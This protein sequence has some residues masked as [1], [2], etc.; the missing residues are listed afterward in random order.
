M[1]PALPSQGQPLEAKPKERRIRRVVILMAPDGA[2]EVSRKELV[3]RDRADM[4][5]INRCGAG[6]EGEASY[7][8]GVEQPPL[9]GPRAGA[10]C[11]AAPGVR[12]ACG[13]QGLP[14]APSRPD[15]R[16]SGLLPI[17]APHHPSLE[18]PPRGVSRGLPLERALPIRASVLSPARTSSPRRC[19]SAV[20]SIRPSP[21]R[22]VVRLSQCVGI[23]VGPPGSGTARSTQ[24]AE[25]P[26]PSA[27]DPSTGA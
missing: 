3:Y 6:A 4:Q 26:P 21:R 11:G 13:C 1:L 17:T 7:E 15:T 9:A 5:I 24:L 14:S 22:C 8:A 10:G 19:V 12:K 25:P 27:P 20:S 18:Q 23:R 2:T 16:R